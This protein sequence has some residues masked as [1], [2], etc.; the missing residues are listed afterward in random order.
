MKTFRI[1]I[2]WALIL[3]VVVSSLLAARQCYNKRHIQTDTVSYRNL[4]PLVDGQFQLVL[5]HNEKRCHQCLTMEEHVNQ[6]VNSNFSESIKDNTLTFKTIVIDEPE[7]IPMVEKL[8]VFAA[9][10]VLME[11]KDSELVYA[12]VLTEGLELYRKEDAF[13]S[14][15]NKELSSILMPSGQ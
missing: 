4:E 3:F 5:F 15:I 7:N 10:I 6:I 14:Y 9:T 8:G 13:K 1:V 12:R 11:F 2:K